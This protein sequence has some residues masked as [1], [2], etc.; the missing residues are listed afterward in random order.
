MHFKTTQVLFQALCSSRNIFTTQDRGAAVSHQ[1]Q[2]DAWCVKR[3]EQHSKEEIWES[4]LHRQSKYPFGLEC[5]IDPALSCKSTQV[6][7]MRFC[8]A[9][10]GVLYLKL[11]NN[12]PYRHCFVEGHQ[13]FTRYEVFLRYE[14]EVTRIQYSILTALFISVRTLPP[15]LFMVVKIYYAS[16]NAFSMTLLIQPA[17]PGR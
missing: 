7:Q 4:M 17:S 2:G 12:H 9:D 3:P 16:I 6:D 1:D 11:K 15:I 10:N 13:N 8:M 14:Q 5:S